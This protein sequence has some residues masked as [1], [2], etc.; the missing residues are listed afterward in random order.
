MRRLSWGVAAA[1]GGPDTQHPRKKS[2][3]AVGPR[4][5]RNIAA[6]IIAT[7]VLAGAGLVGCAAANKSHPLPPE[8][9]SLPQLGFTV[10]MSMPE[11]RYG[12]TF[13][14]LQGVGATWARV[15]AYWEDQHKADLVIQAA[16]AHGVNLLITG[17]LPEAQLHGRDAVNTGQF[18]AQ[19]ADTAQRFKGKGPNGTSPAFEIL[20]EANGS[21]P[22]ATYVQLTCATHAALQAVDPNIRLI[23]GSAQMYIDRPHWD[24]WL[25]ELFD[26]GIG[27]CIE[28]L[29][30]HDYQDISWETP[31]RSAL[32]TMKSI[33][34]EHGYAQMP[35]WL[36][37]FGASTCAG[38]RKPGGCYTESGQAAKIVGTVEELRA[39]Y[40][41]VPVAMIYTDRDI[42]SD[43]SFESSFG[44][45]H[46]DSQNVAAAPKPAVEALKRLYGYGG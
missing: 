42:I 27:R 6:C 8:T 22:A 21:V 26:G 14:D 41:Y 9:A 38:P 31:A 18:A 39:H 43:G 37:E 3:R 15:G 34:V 2:R 1:T 16:T 28:A 17:T 19:M 45:W 44:I 46:A 40:P 20:N 12:E 29:D 13:Q 35:I 33:M 30:A 4:T 24:S 23:A 25:R 36:T 5:P 32:S 7:M 10:R 11:S